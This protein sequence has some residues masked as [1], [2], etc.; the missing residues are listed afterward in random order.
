[1]NRYTLYIDE[2][3]T[4]N[5]ND[6]KDD[7][8]LLT[9]L[10]LSNNI[11]RGF[12]DYFQLIKKRHGID[13]KRNFHSVDFFE[14]KQSS[15]YVSDKKAKDFGATLGEVLDTVPTTILSYQLNKNVL[16][17]ILKIPDD[18]N[19]KGATKEHKADKEIAYELLAR[20]IFL[21]FAK[22]LN[23]N[24]AT[25]N[26]V[27]ESRNVSDTILLK[28]F[29]DCKDASRFIDTRRFAAYADD[30]NEK[31]VSIC[32]ENKNATT[33]GLEIADT[34]SYLWYLE[35]KKRMGERFVLKRGLA[36][37]HKKL[38]KK[39]K[40]PKVT[41]PPMLRSIGKD[42]INKI[43]K[44]IKKNTTLNPVRSLVDPT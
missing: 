5:L 1:M 30:F 25:G 27:A 40:Q 41:T 31:V 14:I 13:G 32:F 26:I 34:I 44:E 15:Q 29:F 43:T 18:Y 22:F 28:T 36:V 10:I 37:L 23:K 8:F 16:R 20:K 4:A 38:R 9:G 24:D 6:K 39:I 11:N 35:I 42:R 19:F 17:K 12:S 7:L 33:A 3:G 2:S 21:D